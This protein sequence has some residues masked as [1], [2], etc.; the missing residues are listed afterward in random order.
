MKP[1]PYQEGTWF[2]VPLKGGG[3][4]AGVVARMAP[5]GRIILTYLFGPRRAALPALADVDHFRAG[6][7][8]RRLRTGDMGLVNRSWPIIGS[9]PSW[10]RRAWPMPAFIRRAEL[11]RR[12][13]RVMYCD[14]DPGRL[15]RE[16]SVPY[17]TGD[18]ESDSLYGYAA[19]ELLMT[20]L[21]A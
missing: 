11:L 14:A 10:D 16:E 20:K 6:D 13:W 7:A 3:Y 12:A 18:L 21:L 4:A 8:L 9:A 17:D 1:L 2:A 19:T 5:P 15:E